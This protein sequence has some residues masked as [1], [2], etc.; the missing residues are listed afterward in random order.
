MAAAS[1]TG[2]GFMYSDFA[3]FYADGKPHIYNTTYGWTHY[4]LEAYGKRYTAMRAF[5]PSPESLHSILFSPNHVRVWSREAYQLAGGHDPSFPVADDHDLIS[6]T[7]L[8]GKP[9]HHIPKCLYLYREHEGGANTYLKHNAEIMRR[10][11][12]VGARDQMGVIRMWCEHNRL[13]M[14]DLSST[15]ERAPDF[16]SVARNNADINCDVRF[17]LPLPDNSVGCLRAFDFLSR[18]NRCPTM[19]CTHGANGHGPRCIVGVLNEFYRVLAPG[20]W[21]MTGTVSSDGRG[22]FQDPTH[23]SFWNPNSFWYYTRREQASFVPGMTSRFYAHRV[24]QTFPNDWHREHDIPMVYANLVALKGQPLAG[25][26]E[27]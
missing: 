6:R 24:W 25:L 26:A 22:A 3:N 27:I 10:S 2:A 7:Y 12:A 19:A 23:Q 5:P 17:G 15:G 11:E 8:T 9:F 4:P 21:L 13:T 20:G 14:L 1:V 16:Q 18:L